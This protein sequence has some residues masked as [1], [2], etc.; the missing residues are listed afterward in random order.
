MPD[1][2]AGHA[3]V[4][5]SKEGFRSRML[6]SIP[7]LV[8]GA[9]RPRGRISLHVRTERMSSPVTAPSGIR[10]AGLGML[11]AVLASFLY[12]FDVSAAPSRPADQYRACRHCARHRW[13]LGLVDGQEG[14]DDGHAADGRALQRHG[15]WRCR[16]DRRGGAFWRQI[17]WDHAAGGHLDWRV[18]RCGVVVRIPG[19]L[20]EA[21]RSDRPGASHQRPAGFE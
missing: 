4:H 21:R 9:R 19:R 17:A 10:V 7:Q 1:E 16:R 11:V 15:R 18:D 12:V 8:I 5:P 6:T 13:R 3:R 20:G 14:G 2:T